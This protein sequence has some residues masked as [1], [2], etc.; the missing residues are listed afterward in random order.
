MS[1]AA[2]AAL[3]HSDTLP[4]NLFA[5]PERSQN[6][7]GTGRVPGQTGIKQFPGDKHATEATASR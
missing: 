1:A 4:N 5:I 2:D 7:K 6:A 3:K